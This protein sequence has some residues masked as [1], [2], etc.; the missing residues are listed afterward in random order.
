LIWF[1]KVVLFGKIIQYFNPILYV[2]LHI[3]RL[4]FLI[5]LLKFVHTTVL[6]SFCFDENIFH[7][8]KHSVKVNLIR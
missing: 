6:S 4:C 8:F 5:L 2:Y 7:P 1:V 3:Q